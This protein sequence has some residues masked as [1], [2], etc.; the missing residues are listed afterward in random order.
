MV[1]L[2]RFDKIDAGAH[3]L[4]AVPCFTWDFVCPVLHIYHA[5]HFFVVLMLDAAFAMIFD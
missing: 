4:F 3:W 2:L 1:V 5:S